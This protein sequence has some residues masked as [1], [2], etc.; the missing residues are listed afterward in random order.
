M[1]NGP[2][3]TVTDANGA[4]YTDEGL[5]LMRRRLKPGG[6]LT[7]WSAAAAREFEA[8]LRRVF[9]TVEVVVVPVARGEPDVVYAASFVRTGAVSGRASSPSSH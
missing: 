7:I 3:W 6:V 1:D 2:A 8:A 9:D 4:L 5:A